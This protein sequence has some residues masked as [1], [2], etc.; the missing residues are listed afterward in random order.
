MQKSSRL[1]V[2]EPS[3]RAVSDPAGCA[4]K[5]HPCADHAGRVR[6]NGAGR[7]GLCHSPRRR[8]PI[9]TLP[10]SARYELRSSASDSATR[11]RWKPATRH[12]GDPPIGL[13]G[14]RLPVEIEENH[15]GQSGGGPVFPVISNHK[16][17]DA[18][19]R[20]RPRR[21]CGIP[22]YA[23]STKLWTGRQSCTSQRQIGNVAG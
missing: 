13:R 3:F 23:K 8:G 17:F 1:F 20:G 12:T 14:Y 22:A 16:D 7:S 9:S 15:F 6:G 5:H 18:A 10:V 4:P 19:D 2:R 11:R 21:R